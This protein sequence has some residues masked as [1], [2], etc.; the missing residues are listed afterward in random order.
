MGWVISRKL[1]F[2]FNEKHLW[3]GSAAGAYN[4]RRGGSL[5]KCGHPVFLLFGAPLFGA[6]RDIARCAKIDSSGPSKAVLVL[7]AFTLTRCS[8]GFSGSKIAPPSVDPWRQ[9]EPD[10]ASPKSQARFLVFPREQE[11]HDDAGYRL[12]MP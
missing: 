2:L 7:N 6:G 10:P 1:T 4:G 8:N 5:H 9:C 12:G 11:T 3:V